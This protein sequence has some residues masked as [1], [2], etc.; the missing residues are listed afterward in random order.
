MVVRGY[1]A[2]PAGWRRLRGAGFGPFVTF[3]EF[4]RPDGSVV[5]WE[6]RWHRKHRAASVQ[7]SVWWAPAALPWWIGVLFAAGSLCFALGS[8]PPYA[9]G[10]GTTGDNVTYFIGSIFFT[11]ASF[12]QYYEVASTPTQLGGGPRRGARALLR[13]EHRRID[14]WAAVIQLAGTLWFNRTTLSALVVGLGASPHHH[15]VWR[16]DA[17]GSMCLLGHV[18][19]DPVLPRRCGASLARADPAGADGGGG[20]AG[21]TPPARREASC[22]RSGGRRSR[23]GVRRRPR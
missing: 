9:I 11:T 23:S 15:P 5:A 16:P 1:V 3:E 7:G 18:R 21:C 17:L 8:F 20:A 12:L 14:W 4:S 22:Y 13:I 2:V 19:R 6:S 10:T